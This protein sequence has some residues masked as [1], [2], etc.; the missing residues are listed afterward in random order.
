MDIKDVVGMTIL[1]NG[2]AAVWRHTLKCPILDFL[3]QIHGRDTIA[4]RWFSC[5]RRTPGDDYIN[6]TLCATSIESWS[7]PIWYL[8]RWRIVRVLTALAE[9]RT[10]SHCRQNHSKH[11]AQKCNR[12]HIGGLRCSDKGL[13]KSSLLCCNTSIMSFLEGSLAGSQTSNLTVP[14]STIV[15]L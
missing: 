14:I 13:F 5:Q 11:S 2:A 10:W 1:W 6:H 4:W 12:S 8:W 9:I 15:R 3:L 7:P